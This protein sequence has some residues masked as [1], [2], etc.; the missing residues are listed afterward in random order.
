MPMNYDKGI[1]KKLLPI[2]WAFFI[3]AFNVAFPWLLVITIPLL[4]FY[5]KDKLGK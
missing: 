3:V 5:F 4:F 1:D 2:T